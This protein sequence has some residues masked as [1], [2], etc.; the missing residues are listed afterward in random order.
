[1]GAYDEGMR[2]WGGENLEISFR[3]WMCGGVLEIVPCSRIGHVFRNKTPYTF[4]GGTETVIHA[5][6]RRSI[7]VWTDD[8]KQF[9]Y[10]KT[11]GKHNF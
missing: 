6:M 2:V 1:M 5:N 11:P 7:E 9:F 4:P 8:Y 10:A 3:M